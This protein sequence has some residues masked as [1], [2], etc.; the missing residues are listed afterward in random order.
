MITKKE[1]LH[2]VANFNESKNI[3]DEYVSQL[4]KELLMAQKK[5]DDHYWR[6]IAELGWGTKTT[7]YKALK[8]ELKESQ[9]EAT[10]NQLEIFVW[11]KQKGLME[12]LVDAAGSEGINYASDDGFSDLT[13]HIVGLGKAK[14]LEVI[15]RPSIAMEMGI[16][17]D[18]AESFLYVFR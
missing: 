3:I 2:A 5:P 13:A 16:N 4:E 8:Q 17:I 11:E 12:H 15:D 1:Y 6:I 14:Y 7:D 10:I 18:Y 9:T